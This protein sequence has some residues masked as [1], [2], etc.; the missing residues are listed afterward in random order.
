[1]PQLKPHQILVTKEGQRLQVESL[2]AEGG[3]GE[4]YKVL[5]G[6]K[7]YALKW[8]HIP[9]TPAQ[10]KQT[11]EQ[12]QALEHYLLKNAAP[13]PRFLWPITIVH[14]PKKR[15]FGYLMDLLSPRFQGLE[16]LVLGKMRPV[17]KF[18]ILCKAAIGLAECFRKLHNMGACYKDINLGGPFID[19]STGDVMICDTDNVRVNKTP[20]N[21]IFIFFHDIANEFS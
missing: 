3:Q 19:P 11:Q 4:V 18:R 5:L 8:Y 12:Y 1:M 10:Q 17:P 16:K 15:S 9:S 6:N 20:G 14:D 21:I 13:D 2:I 7:S